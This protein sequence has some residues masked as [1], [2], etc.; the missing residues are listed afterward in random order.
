MSGAVQF[1]VP[2]FFPQRRQRGRTLWCQRTRVRQNRVVLAVVATAKLFAEVQGSQPG[3]V[4]R[5]FAEVREARRNSAPGR[6]RHK[7]STHR[8]GKAVCWAS[9]VCCCAVLSACAFRA[10]DRGCRRHPAFPAPLDERVA[11][12]SKAR[13]NCAARTRRRVCNSKCEEE[14]RSCCLILR[15]CERSGPD[16][17]RG[18]TPRSR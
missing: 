5:Q 2:T 10:V 11:R 8:A 12:R 1:V 15:H 3:E 6:A 4:H 18:E 14:E 9:P 7:P 13:A 16:S 17:H